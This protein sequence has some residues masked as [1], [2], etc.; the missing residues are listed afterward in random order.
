MFGRYANKRKCPMTYQKT[1]D[2]KTVTISKASVAVADAFIP[3]KNLFLVS[4]LV[5]GPKK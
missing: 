1:S 5:T 3:K 4:E 2:S